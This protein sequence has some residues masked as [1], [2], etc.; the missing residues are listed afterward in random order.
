MT[1]RVWP[2]DPDKLGATPDRNGVNFALFSQNA[3]RVE[4]CLFSDD[5]T[6]ELERIAMPEY[7]NQVWHCYVPGMQVGQLYGYRVYGPYAPEHGH[8]FNHHKLLID[9]YARKLVGELQWHPANFGYRLGDA[10]EDLSFDPRD[11]ARYV[12]KCQVVD[13][14]FTWQDDIRPKVSWPD[15]VL[16]ELH[17]RGFTQ[18][19]PRVEQGTAG[20]FTALRHP[21]VLHYLRDL[22]VTTLELL[23]VHAYL[24][25]HYLAE[26]GLRNF[27]GYTSL[28]FFAPQPRYLHQGALEDVQ[29]FV[30]AAHR[31]GLEVVLDVVYNHTGEGNQLGPTLC[32]RGIDNAVYYRLLADNPRY[33]S[34]STGTGNSLAIFQPQVLR[35][36]LDS[37]RYWVEVLH[38]DGF[39]F[40]LA[41]TLGRNAAGHFDLYSGFLCALLQD[42]VL[43]GVK[44]IA[45]PWDV[46]EGGYRVGEFPSGFAEWNDRYRDTLRRFWRA[47]P[48][49][50]SD[51]ATRLTGSS[52]LFDRHGRRPW[53]SINAV[54]MHDGFTLRDLVSY[55]QKHNDANP[56]DNTDGTDNNLSWNCGAEGPTDDPA[57]NTLRARQ[58]RNLLAS[59]FLSQG[60]PMLLAGDELNNS[61]QG[62]NNAYCQD[63]ELSWIDWSAFD[64]GQTRALHAFTRALIKLRRDHVVLRRKHFFIGQTIPGSDSTDIVWLNPDG[65][66]R[67]TSDWSAADEGFLGFMI[68][69]EAGEYHLTTSGEHAHD[70]TLLVGMNAGKEGIQL[71]LPPCRVGT[72]WEWTIDTDRDDG[73]GTGRLPCGSLV[74]VAAHSVIVMVSVSEPNAEQPAQ[75]PPAAQPPTSRPPSRPDNRRKTSGR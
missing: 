66:P 65:T 49:L 74:Q 10:A 59:L 72:H 5:G 38:I 17:V 18:R 4:L 30:Q 7:T 24:D 20:T 41:S 57:V 42:P 11:S 39:R 63:N 26:H 35:M 51:L 1:H 27:W 12:P 22:G 25:D 60:T 56:H 34:D 64:D 43:S 69:G 14:T 55:N 13:T 58:Q 61:Q 75:Q 68:S 3:E 15:T 16:Y 46:S 52:D 29:R 70:V 71:W 28:S 6:R 37:L 19:H 33:Y 8:R 54:T 9:P 53:A 67:R 31:A 23:P 73:L 21:E 45:E 2:G 36:V 48:G 62:N 47:D 50:V 44:L 32:Y 40:D